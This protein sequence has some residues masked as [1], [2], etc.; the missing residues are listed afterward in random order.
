MG[1]MTNETR[2]ELSEATQLHVR[3]VEQAGCEHPPYYVFDAKVV[4][5]YCALCRQQHVEHD[6]TWSEIPEPDGHVLGTSS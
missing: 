6:P 1:T 4:E 2:V 5:G 3:L